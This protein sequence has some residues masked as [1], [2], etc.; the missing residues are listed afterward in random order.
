MDVPFLGRQQTAFD[1]GLASLHR[2][3][4]AP[5]WFAVLLVDPH[6]ADA[7]PAFQLHLEQL[8]ARR[9]PTDE[10]CGPDGGG[11]LRAYAQAVDAAVRM[12][13]AQ[14][15]WWHRRWARCESRPDT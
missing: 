12:A 5:V 7:V 11:V 4:G 3:T 2:A 15:F 9:T 10:R 1:S 8:A 6:R 14:Y 13:P